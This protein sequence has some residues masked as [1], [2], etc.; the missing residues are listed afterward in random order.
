MDPGTLQVMHLRV[1]YQ[2]VTCQ[3]LIVSARVWL[4]VV[5]L[6]RRRNAVRGP[7]N[8]K[9]CWSVAEGCI[10]NSVDSRVSGRLTSQRARHAQ[11][12]VMPRSVLFFMPICLN[13]RGRGGTIWSFPPICRG[14]RGA[15]LL[16]GSVPANLSCYG[17]ESEYD[18]WSE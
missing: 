8:V 11:I 2:I 10:T 15:I 3:G 12:D 5:T 17:A 4:N 16:A 6:R 13:S 18:D 9:I 7:R 14:A 1:F